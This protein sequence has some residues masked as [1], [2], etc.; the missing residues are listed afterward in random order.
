MSDMFTDFSTGEIAVNC[1]HNYVAQE[2]HFGERVWLTRKG[3]VSA[4]EGELGIIPGSMGGPVL[5]RARKRESG[6]FLYLRAWRRTCDVPQR[7]QEAL[8]C[9]GSREGNRRS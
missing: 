5:H 3:A 8:Q 1:H 7:G 9:A 4:K 2:R 6:F